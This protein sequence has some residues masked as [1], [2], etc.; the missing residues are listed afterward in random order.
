VIDTNI[1]EFRR[2]VRAAHKKGQRRVVVAKVRRGGR[3]LPWRTAI[4]ILVVLF[5]LKAFIVIGVGEKKYR[6][7]LAAYTNPEFGQKVG[8][9]FMGPDPVTLKIRDIVAPIIAK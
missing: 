9:F 7:Q 2:R 6:D 3:S 5:L 4:N 8:L 1:E